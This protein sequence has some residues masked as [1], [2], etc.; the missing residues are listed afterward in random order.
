M[1]LENSY[2]I[3]IHVYVTLNFI[4]RVLLDVIE[5]DGKVVLKSTFTLSG[6]GGYNW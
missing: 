4:I 1:G 2:I 3:H 6:Q 5:T